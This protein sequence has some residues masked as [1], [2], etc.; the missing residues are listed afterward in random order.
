MHRGQLGGALTGLR[1]QPVQQHQHPFAL[2]VA[3][4]F[5]G[6]LSTPDRKPGIHNPLQYALAVR[7]DLKSQVRDATYDSPAHAQKP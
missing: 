5:K 2:A 6:G 1:Q 7:L 4:Q 3:G